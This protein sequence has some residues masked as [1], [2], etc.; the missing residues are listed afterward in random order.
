M[1]LWYCGFTRSGGL[2]FFWIKVNFDASLR[3]LMFLCAVLRFSDPPLR[4][5]I[6]LSFSDGH[7]KIRMHVDVVEIPQRLPVNCWLFWQRMSEFYRM[8]CT[9]LIDRAMYSTVLSTVVYL[10]NFLSLIDVCVVC[11]SLSLP[12]FAIL[13]KS[14]KSVCL[15]LKQ[16]PLNPDIV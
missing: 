8:Q 2:L 4:P 10:T 7:K 13:F 5:S 15:I 1:S 9:Y 3:I 16:T 6:M 11:S 12:V 14:V